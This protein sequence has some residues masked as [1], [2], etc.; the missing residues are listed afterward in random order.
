MAGVD[1]D[2]RGSVEAAVRRAF[3]RRP[4]SESWSVSLVRLA[5]KWSVTLSGPGERFRNLSFT[6]DESR[7]AE[8]IG[9]AIGG[10]H[11]GPAPGPAASHAPPPATVRERHVC[12]RCRQAILVVYESR[13]D[14]SKEL[15]PIACPHCWTV[16][17][18]EI[19][20]WA[21]STSDYRAE[22]A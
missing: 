1:K 13:P 5:G 19:G 22:K 10:E 8:A 7:L 11:G 3:E 12:E 4:V 15:A 14:D 2:A 9:E 21:A 16:N 20:A 18:V 6:A 17:H